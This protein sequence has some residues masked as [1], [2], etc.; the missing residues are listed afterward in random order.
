MSYTAIIYSIIHSGL[1]QN[2]NVANSV[3]QIRSV[4]DRIN[5]PANKVFVTKGE[6]GR[7]GL[8]DILGVIHANM[9]RQRDIHPFSLC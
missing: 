1:Y 3:T 9:D 6:N 2:P 4:L 7:G 5:V 8:L